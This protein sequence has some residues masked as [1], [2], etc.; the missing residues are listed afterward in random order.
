MNLHLSNEELGY[1][2]SGGHVMSDL[3]DKLFRAV[4]LSGVAREIRMDWDEDRVLRLNGRRAIEVE[5]D[6]NPSNADAT[7]AKVVEAIREEV[8]SIP[9]PDGYQ[10][11]WVGEGELQGEAIGNLMKYVPLTVFLILGI[12]MLLFNSWRKV[13]LILLSFTYVY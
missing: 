11:R 13:I 7:P 1:A 9:L 10:M 6:P 5:C 8:E 3:Q 12:L 4:P 2:L